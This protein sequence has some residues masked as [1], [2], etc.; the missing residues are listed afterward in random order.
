MP[1]STALKRKK[2]IKKCASLSCPEV[3]ENVTPCNTCKQPYHFTNGN[4]DETLYDL[5]S[6]STCEACNCN[7]YITK[8]VESNA[9]MEAVRELGMLFCVIAPPDVR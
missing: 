6:V 3:N 9:F 8:P 4:F 5:L 7:L 2:Q 1:A